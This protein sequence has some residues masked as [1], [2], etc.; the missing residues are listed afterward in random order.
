[1]KNLSLHQSVL[2]QLTATSK[3]MPHALLLAGSGGVG[4]KTIA[5]EIAKPLTKHLITVE[6][7][8]KGTISIESIRDL[9]TKTRAKQTSRQIILIDDADAMSVAAQNA[10]LKLLEEPTEHTS[11]LLTTHSPDR[12]LSTIKSRVQFIN[13]QQITPSQTEEHLNILEV[14]DKRKRQQLAFIAAGLPAELFRLTQDEE[15]F[16]EQA[17]LARKAREFLSS[18]QYDRLVTAYKV[19]ADRDQ[20]V[21]LVDHIARILKYSLEN[22]AKRSLALQL[23]K[24]LQAAESIKHNGHVRT[25]LLKLA[26]S[27]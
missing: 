19:G 23:D 14:T 27:L 11:F 22:N 3:K 13:I 8:E 5:Q 17:D 25:Q 2:K 7:D 1:M 18:K 20:A 26:I 24:A 4:L 10:F 6:P 9:Y 12:L 21:Q 15:Y 16:N